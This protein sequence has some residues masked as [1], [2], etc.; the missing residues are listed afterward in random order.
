M[1]S[2]GYQKEKMLLAID[3]VNDLATLR[4]FLALFVDTRFA[5]RVARLHMWIVLY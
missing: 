4:S 3:S 5:F 1:R 2:L